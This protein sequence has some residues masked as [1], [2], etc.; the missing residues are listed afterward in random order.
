MKSNQSK[1]IQQRI[2]LLLLSEDVK[3]IDEEI[4]DEESDHGEIDDVYSEPQRETT[5]TLQEYR[6]AA[7]KF[8]N[9]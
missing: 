3:V 4:V 9:L 6:G 2:N 5:A 7:H 1:E 8:Y